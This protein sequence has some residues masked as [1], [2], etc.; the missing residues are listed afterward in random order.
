MSSRGDSALVSAMRL[1]DGDG[2]V[3]EQNRAMAELTGIEA[4]SE[5]DIPCMEQLSCSMCLTE[6]CVLERLRDGSE[7]WV[8]ETVELELPTGDRVPTSMVAERL[9]AEDGS[10]DGIVESFLEIPDPVAGSAVDHRMSVPEPTDPEGFRAALTAVLRHAEREG[11]H[12]SDRS[13]ECSP[14]RLA[15]SWDVEIATVSK[16]E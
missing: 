2:L 9:T 5:E 13:W 14:D 4:E 8:T 3:V 1:I 10:F 11:V 6:E 16:T 7:E 12:F 15:G